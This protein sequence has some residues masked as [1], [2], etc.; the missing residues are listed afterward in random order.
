MV[1]KDFDIKAFAYFKD[2]KISLNGSVLYSSSETELPEILKDIYKKLET[3]YRKFF[4]MDVLSK[5]AFL[6]ADMLLKSQNLAS[7]ENDIA[8][9]LSN[10]ASSLDTD[11]NHQNTIADKD[12]YY[13]S[14]A[15][16]VY[17]LANICIGEISIK[18]KLFSENSFFIFE[19]FNAQ[20]LHAYANQLLISKKAKSVLCGWVNVDEEKY[21]AFLYLVNETNEKGNHTIAEIN[22]LY[23]N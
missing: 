20:Y 1:N 13:P 2:G 8:V 21:E 3:D 5:V 23:N 4:K 7:E 22:R 10:N 19:A 18:Y 12:N 17:T 16:F 14:P 11:R 6:T 15:V 9:I